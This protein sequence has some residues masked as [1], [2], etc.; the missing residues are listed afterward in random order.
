LAYTFDR[1]VMLYGN[2]VEGMLNKR[3]KSGKR[4]HTLDEILAGPGAEPVY[5][6]GEISG[7]FGNSAEVVRD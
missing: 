2:Y 3:S 4:W 7:M 1:F 5:S 6:L